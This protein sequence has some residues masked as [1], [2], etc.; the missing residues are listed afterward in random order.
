MSTLLMEMNKE[1]K[2]VCNGNGDSQ[3]LANLRYNSLDFLLLVSGFSQ[4]DIGQLM[5][6]LSTILTF[7]SEEKRNSYT[8]TDV[9]VQ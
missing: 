1:K 3:P 5:G 7:L 2:T 4:Q 9:N 8:L 6:D